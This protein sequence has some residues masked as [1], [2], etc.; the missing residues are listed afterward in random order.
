MTT[1]HELR[2]KLRKIAALFE[3]ATSAGE[4]DAAAAALGRITEE[5]V[6]RYFAVLQKALTQHKGS[7]TAEGSGTPDPS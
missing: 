3:G 6:R 5:R 2:Q 1:E 4:R 7:P